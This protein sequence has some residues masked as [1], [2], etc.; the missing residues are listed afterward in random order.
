MISLEDIEKI[1]ADTLKLKEIY[2]TTLQ[3]VEKN[4]T[5]MFSIS[6]AARKEVDFQR[7]QLADIKGKLIEVIANVDYLENKTQ[8]GKQSLAAASKAFS[9]E[10]MQDLYGEVA[11]MLDK[12]QYA[13]QKEEHLR[14]QRDELELSLRRLEGLLEQS[15]NMTLA[16]GSVATY[17]SSQFNKITQQ[18]EFTQK[19]QSIGEHV[20]MAHEEERKR[21]SRNLHDTVAQGLAA[22]L[23]QLRICKLAL[24]DGDLEGT[25]HAIDDTSDNIK[26]CLSDTRQ[27]IFDM[28]PMALDD[29]GLAFAIHQLCT[30]HRD[31]QTLHIDYSLNGQEYPLPKHVEIMIY[32]TV[33]ESLSNILHHSGQTKGSID[34]NYAANALNIVIKDEGKGFDLQEK[35][36]LAAEEGDSR[37]H[38]GLDFMKEGARSAGAELSISSS[39]GKGTTVRI[40][41]PRQDWA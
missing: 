1:S 36:D 24:A 4:K 15:E 18:V 29:K 38:F 17:L 25:A 27:V 37:H 23:M 30:T 22:A 10:D 13:R 19:C 33:Q 16:I 41:V 2:R 8:L 32:R 35:A 9:T 20:I 26:N 14:Q 5:Q 40:K 12:L 39:P 7:K 11:F 31:K 21:I 28:R 6:E 3:T 34:I